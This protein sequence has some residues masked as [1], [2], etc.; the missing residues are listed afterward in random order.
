[1]LSSHA[2]S[3]CLGS[4]RP[5]RRQASIVTSWASCIMCP[6]NMASS[7]VGMSISSKPA[8]SPSWLAGWKPSGRTMSKIYRISL[9]TPRLTG[10]K[11][12]IW[13]VGR[14]WGVREAGIPASSS[15]SRQTASDGLSPLL[16]PPPVRLSSL[17]GSTALCGLRRLSK[18][19][20]RLCFDQ[21]VQMHSLTHQ[22][23]GRKAA[24][25]EC[26]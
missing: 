25:F 7:R 2:D 10:R 6:P 23:N 22:P 1:M 14:I 11:L 16:I 8:T 12:C 18:S 24:R 20:N 19:A 5:Y 3:G 9:W 15:P 17:F 13:A 21:S 26:A 4:I